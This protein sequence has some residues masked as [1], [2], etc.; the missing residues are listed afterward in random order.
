[1][2]TFVRYELPD[3]GEVYFEAPDS[4]LVTPRGGAADVVDRGL[5]TDQVANIAKVASFTARSF[6]QI[7][8]PDELQLEFGVTVGGSVN[9]WFITSA[10]AEGSI[11]VTLKWNNSEGVEQINPEGAQARNPEGA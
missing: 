4:P 3:G 6:R 5:L 7:L 8:G 11:K 9:W 1:V 10:K 2:G